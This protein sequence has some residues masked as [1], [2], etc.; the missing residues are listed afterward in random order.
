MNSVPLRRHIGLA[1]AVF[2]LVGYVIGASIFVLPGQ[3]GARAGPALFLSYLL[4]ALLAAL[5]GLA[6]A[7]IGS[8]LPV[9]GSVYVSISRN[10]GARQ[11]FLTLWALLLAVSVGVPLVAYG[12]AEYVSFFIPVLPRRLTALVVVAGF[13][14]IN[15]TPV[16]GSVLVQSL[17][18]AGFLILLYGFGVAAVSHIDL[19]RFWP[20]FANGVTPVLGAAVGAYF[21]YT[22]F[23]AIADIAEE[24]RNPGRT[25][26]WAV[27]VSFATVTVAYLMIAIAVTGLLD[28]QSLAQVPAPVATAAETFLSHR[29]VG[30][31]AIAAILAAATSIH[32]VLLVHSRDVYALARDQVFPSV[33]GYVHPRTGIP[34]GGVVTLTVLSLIGVLFGASLLD[35]ALLT[36]LGVMV[37]QGCAGLA[38]LRMPVHSTPTRFA[39]R[40]RLRTVVGKGLVITSAGFGLVGAIDRSLVALLFA[41]IMGAGFVYYSARR[42]TLAALGHQ[43]DDILAHTQDS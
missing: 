32:G 4:A 18:T 28:W 13:G 21:S 34:T 43:L 35:Y 41:L 36:V 7:H 3:L 19:D 26:P 15:L 29:A 23:L 25:L 2:T 1:G 30:F 33:F 39:L 40:G 24:I 9:S 17:L 11:G 5:S 37:V 6:A 42:R 31:I 10:L 8:Q 16:R 38:L 22:G 27:A 12:L 20:L 14:A